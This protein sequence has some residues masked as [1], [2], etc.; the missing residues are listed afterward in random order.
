MNCDFVALSKEPCHKL[1]YNR[2]ASLVN[3]EIEEEKMVYN[4]RAG[5]VEANTI[6]LHHKTI[7]GAKFEGINNKCCDVFKLHTKKKVKGMLYQFTKPSKT[8]VVLLYARFRFLNFI[9]FYIG[10]RVISLELAVKFRE[11][12]VAVIP[13]WQLCRNCWYKTVSGHEVYT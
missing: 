13:G 5:A 3:F 11:N 4:W 10:Y 1:S 8:L 9:T 6:C 2:S 7:Y 12:G